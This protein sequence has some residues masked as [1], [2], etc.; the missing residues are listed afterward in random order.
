[1]Y[2]GVNEEF[3]IVRVTKGIS[4]VTTTNQGFERRSSENRSGQ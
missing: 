2:L 1:M 4:Y 3:F